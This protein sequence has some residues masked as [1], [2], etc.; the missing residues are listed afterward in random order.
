MN[1]RTSIM[2]RMFILMGLIFLLPFAILVQIFRVNVMEGDGLRELWNSQAIDY[3]AIPA[4]RGNIYDANGSLLATNSAVYKIAVDPFAPGVTRDNLD[5]VG[6]VLS[7]HTGRQASY[8]R[9]KIR[10]APSNSRYIV[11]ERSISV[12][13]YED[14]REL[15]YRGVIL[16]EEYRRNYNFETL[17][18]HTLGYVNHN[19]D[20][21][22]GLEAKYNQTLKGEDGLQQ[23][24]RDRSNRIFAYVGAPRQQPRQG[25]SLHTTIDSYI[26]AIVEEELENGI[27]TTRAKQGTAIVMDP[28]TGAVKAM[29]NYPTFDPNTPAASD[30][31]NRRN[32]AVSDMFEPGST[33]KLVT[34][35]AAVEQGVVDFDEIFET[36]ENG[37]IQ[38][39]G[40]WMRD[41]DPLGDLTFKQAIAKSSNI[42][43]SELA[44]RI[45]PER[46]Y[47]YARNLGFGT[48]T[49]IDL[50]NE[51]G[52]RLQKP[53]EWSGVT[54]PW[55]SIGYEVQATP[56]QIVQAYAAFANGG[57]MMKP[58]VV[59]HLTDEFGNVKERTRPSLVRRI[60]KEETIQKLMPVFEEVVTDSGTANWASVEGLRIAGK[61]GTAQK[62]IGGRYTTS[63][64]A[65]FAGFF[66]VEDPSY[67][68]LVLLD[69]PRTSFYGGFT[70]GSVFREITKRIAGLDD[71]INRSIS[72]GDQLAE[73]NRIFIPQLVGHTEA[74]AES[75]LK[76][77]GIRYRTSGSGPFVVDQQ[78]SA[79]EAIADNVVVKLTLGDIQDGESPDGF[80]KIPDLREMNMRKAAS[81]IRGL[82]LE[83]EMIGS[84]TIYNQFPLA[85]ELMREGR[86]VTVRGRAR[87][88]QNVTLT[89]A[90]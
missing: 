9:N 42:A 69:E 8:Y 51:V 64:R 32:Y 83:I 25:S 17:S 72:P 56:L 39:H 29:A 4:Q 50:H 63:Y 19:L 36:P 82:G 37:R 41:H 14:I 21:M 15:G 2:S 34:A 61:T 73:E 76:G 70:A 59:S 55:M 33:F 80:V 79:A 90:Q 24:R 23:V 12:Q 57:K 31:E 6:S 77:T 45:Q 44:M 68:I 16:E 87:S 38:I 27:Q 3:I 5:M 67:V 28:K 20:G 10:N 53:F 58:F 43:T 48:P 88:M 30:T 65:S 84:G 46:Y 18:A 49:N 85:G 74:G 13:A 78:P 1:H 52:G 35:I 7:R 71:S 26:Q 40:Q 86:T 75:I 60:A 11:L 47:Q 22:A 62:Y 81:V 54:L 89:A 66:P